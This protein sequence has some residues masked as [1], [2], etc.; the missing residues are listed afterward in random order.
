MDLSFLFIIQA[1]PTPAA[2]NAQDIDGANVHVWV[3]ESTIIA[4]EAAARSH[5]L[6]YAWIPHKVRFSGEVTGDLIAALDEFELRN[7]KE[8]ILNGISAAF[9]GWTKETMSPEFFEYR[10]L[11]PPLDAGKKGIN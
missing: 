2:R 8:A 7:Y 3:M 5:I 10:P 1:E 9:Y 4:A 6:G 11:G